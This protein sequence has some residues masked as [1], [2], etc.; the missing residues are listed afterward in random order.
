MSTPTFFVTLIVCF[1]SIALAENFKTI[2]GK[3]YKNVEVGRVEPDGLVLWSKSGISKVYFSELPKEVVDKWLPPEE[4]E[5]VAAEKAAEEKRIQEQKAAEAERA[6][7]EHEREEK[8]KNADADLRRAA[9]QFQT[10]EQ[11]AAQSHRTAA[12]GTLSGQIFV[13]TIGGE[14]FKLGGGSV[15]LFERKAIEALIA[16]EK[17]YADIKIQHLS[18]DVDAAKA[19]QDQADAAQK[20]WFEA[21]LAV[22]YNDPNRDTVRQSY[23]QARTAADRA[24]A[25]YQK[26]RESR[27]F[28]YSGAFYFGLL[29]NPIQ[30][31][32]T[33]ADGKFAIQVPITGGFVVAAKAERYV[34]LGYTEYYYWLQP[35]SL[36][37]QQQLVQ[38]LSSNNL[39]STKGTSPLLHTQD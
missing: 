15:S 4:K 35:V 25:E 27:D 7:K 23:T 16:A 21:D 26:V 8:E 20:Y 22:H 17:I 1:A 13:S 3:E 24:E 11:R 9:E 19:V 37:G 38:N 2:N 28:Y 39:T 34:P 5:R 36:D 6:L 32:E 30:T 31:A 12:K 14:N 10:T 29:S 18:F 33:D